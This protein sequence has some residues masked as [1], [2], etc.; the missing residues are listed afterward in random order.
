[1]VNIKAKVKFEHCL[2]AIEEYIRN[3]D[4]EKFSL[5]HANKLRTMAEEVE[6]KVKYYMAKQQ[7]YIDA[8]HAKESG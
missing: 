6:K 1:M 4:G 3:A 7:L 5:Y 2:K 8:E